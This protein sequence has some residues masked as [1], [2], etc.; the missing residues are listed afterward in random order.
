MSVSIRLL[1]PKQKQMGDKVDRL[2][3]KRKPKKS[4]KKESFELFW[5]IIITFFKGT[6]PIEISL[7]DTPKRC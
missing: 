5:N 2:Q 4:L 7:C 3:D 6:Y 1:A